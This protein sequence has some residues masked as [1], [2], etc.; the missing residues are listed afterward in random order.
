MKEFG[1]EQQQR[2]QSSK[3]LVV[4]AGGL[5]SPVLL[6]LS[7]AGVG[8]IGIVEFDTVD[9][10][11]L[12][13]QILY[14]TDDI[15][16]SKLDTAIHHLQK[17][18]PHTTYIPHDTAITRHNAKA[19]IRPYDIVIDGSDNFPTRYLVND[20]CVLENKPCVH[21]SVLRFEG[22]VSVF[23]YDYGDGKRS[24]NYRDLFPTPPPH[25][26]VPN[27]AEA[28]VLGVLP[29]I[30]GSMQASE[31]IKIAAQIGDPLAGRLWIFDAL[32]FESRI[33]KYK[34]NP[35]TI[36]SELVDYELFCGTYNSTISD[37]SPK[38]A[39]DLYVNEDHTLFIDVREVDEYLR[40]NIGAT[41]LP[42]SRLDQTKDTIDYSKRIIIHCQSG[43]RSRQ[44]IDLLRRE[45][46]KARFYNLN[47]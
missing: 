36:I 7:A 40:D 44:A 45:Q 14:T 3:I 2:L 29:G 33:L 1:I 12:Q 35:S 30:I 23:N 18:N 16:T 17:I 38:E 37:I 13:R 15:G 24:P 5:G 27:C 25:G 6:Y 8:T 43:I 4:G 19:I 21:G 46:P 41:S 26:L 34:N 39:M 31:A 42:L 20:V 9:I 47:G 28:G 11:N 32:S 22:Q 10:S